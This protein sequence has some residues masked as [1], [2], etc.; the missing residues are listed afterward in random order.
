MNRSA[1][2]VFGHI[3]LIILGLY[4]IIC[5]KMIA[6]QAVEAQLKLFHHHYNERG[7]Q[8]GFLLG[9]IFFVAVGT[10]TLSGIIK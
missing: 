3:F 9:G 2:D 8:I 6:H 1:I 7:Y 5:H 10:L 4:F